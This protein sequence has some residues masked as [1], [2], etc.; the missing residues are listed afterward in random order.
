MQI[1][2]KNVHLNKKRHT[3]YFAYAII[4]KF[5]EDIIVGEEITF[6]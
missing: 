5:A 2:Y 6:L 3:Q 1:Y 4:F